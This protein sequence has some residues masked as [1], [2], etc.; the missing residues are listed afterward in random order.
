MLCVVMGVL[1]SAGLLKFLD[2]DEFAGAVGTWTVLPAMLRPV[3]VVGMPSFE[4]IIGGMWFLGLAPRGA[5]MAAACLLVIVSAAYAVQLAYGEPPDCGCFGALAQFKWAQ[6]VSESVL[7]RNGVML[8][9]L[10]GGVALGR[11]RGPDSVS[12]PDK[13]AR[14]HRAP[15]GFTLIE[16]LL[17]VALLATLVATLLP[18]LAHTRTSVRCARSLATARSHATVFATYCN[19]FRGTWPYVT[20]PQVHYTILRASDIT[21]PVVYFQAANRWNV[22]LAESYYAGAAVH[23]VFTFPGRRPTS[24]TVYNYSQAML[25][26][27]AYWN[28]A[29]RTGP[30]QWR[31]TSDHEVTFPSSKAI[32]VDWYSGHARRRDRTKEL[33]SPIGMVFCD[34]SARQVPTSDVLPGY[35]QFTGWTWQGVYNSVLPQGMH[36]IDGVRGRD[37]K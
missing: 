3:I 30:A 26:D 22:G 34:T 7:A 8:A 35:R 27:P 9:A 25:A 5:P 33:G 37:V 20:D 24:F 18:S 21:V 32:I 17:V 16:T 12:S 2:L 36:T 13:G 6:T 23:E 11:K 1:L 31:P 14:T 10:L 19:D 4:V 28:E 29:T 15:P